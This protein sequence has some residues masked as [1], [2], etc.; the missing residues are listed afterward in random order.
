MMQPTRPPVCELQI[1]DVVVLRSGG[2]SM[3]VFRI[4]PAANGRQIVRV[5]FYQLTPSGWVY[6]QTWFDHRCLKRL[7]NVAPQV[8]GVINAPADESSDE[9]ETPAQ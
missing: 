4:E 2:P 7:D 1:G 6:C 5:E 9:A 3:S 8:T